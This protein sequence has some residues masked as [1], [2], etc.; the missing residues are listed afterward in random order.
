MR[1]QIIQ[2][3]ESRSFT[4]DD[5]FV[6]DASE[7]GNVIVVLGDQSRKAF[8]ELEDNSDVKVI[9][10]ELGTECLG[11]HTGENAGDEG[12]H[13][14]GF[15]R[16]R[17]GDDAA[18]NLVEIVRQPH[19]NT[20]AVEMARTLFENAGLEVA[21]CN[22]F[23]GRIIDRLVRPYYNEALKRLDEGLATASDMDLTLK[24]GLGYPDGPI[25]LLERSGL[26]HHYDVTK[27]LFEI[28]GE[29]YYAPARRATVAYQRRQLN[30]E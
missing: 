5:S 6:I 10:V 13:V 19:T 7:S 16:F 17:L 11:V 26:A 21:V 12:S 8:M 24:L 2:Q 20:D 4:S 9:L 3:G 28:Y 25:S 29:K 15:A 27:A 18:S 22:D 14:I 30:Q 1:Y 23:A